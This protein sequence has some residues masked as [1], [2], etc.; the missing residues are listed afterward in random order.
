MIAEE[1]DRLLAAF[2]EGATSEQEEQR[3]REAFL[4]DE[5]PARLL[6]EKALFLSLCGAEDEEIP[7][8]AGL[9]ERLASAIDARAGEEQPALPALRKSRRW[10][11]VSGIAATLLLLIGFGTGLAYLGRDTVPTTTADTFSDPQEAYRVLRSTLMEV[12]TNL[13]SGLAQLTETQND[14]AQM[15]RNVMNELNTQ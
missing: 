9:E 2:Y 4:H 14:V 12:S 13:N 3:L 8:S 10:L 1:F 15:N 6:R 5:V 11:Q 7:V